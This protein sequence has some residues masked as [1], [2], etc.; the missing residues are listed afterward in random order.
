ML[1]LE[2]PYLISEGQKSSWLEVSWDQRSHAAFFL[3]KSF[4]CFQSHVGSLRHLFAT[5]WVNEGLG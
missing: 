2:L 5:L 1:I 3:A 4:T